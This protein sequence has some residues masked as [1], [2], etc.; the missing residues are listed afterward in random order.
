[1]FERVSSWTALAV[2]R[3]CTRR[4]RIKRREITLNATVPSRIGFVGNKLCPCLRLQIASCFVRMRR[5]KCCETVSLSPFYFAYLTYHEW[6][7]LR[8]EKR[9]FVIVLKWRVSRDVYR[10]KFRTKYNKQVSSIFYTFMEVSFFNIWR[11]WRARFVIFQLR[12]SL[13]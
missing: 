9:S 8:S 12:D 6:P 2:V 7:R 11:D 3:A 5:R 10:E 1:M 13:W 4:C